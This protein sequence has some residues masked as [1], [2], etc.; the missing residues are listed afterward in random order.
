MKEEARPTVEVVRTRHA[1]VLVDGD[2]G[3]VISNV[4]P[5]R[6]ARPCRR[7]HGL[8]T[9]PDDRARCFRRDTTRHLR[10]QRCLVAKRAAW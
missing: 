3:V 8:I 6:A 1:W 4:V 10:L 5:V 9:G 2:T 7:Q